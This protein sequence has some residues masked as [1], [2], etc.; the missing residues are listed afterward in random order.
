MVLN[1]KNRKEYVVISVS[2]LVEK[3]GL[4]DLIRAIPLVKNRI[5]LEIVGS[6]PLKNKLKALAEQLGI[7]GRVIFQGEVAHNEV[8]DI[9]KNVDVF[10]RPSLSE[11]LGTAFIEAMAA[12][13]P[14]IGTPVGGITDLIT[15]DETG[16]LCTPGDVQGIADA[17]DKILDDQSFA[18]KISCAG[19]KFVNNLE[20]GN[21]A[22]KYGNIYREYFQRSS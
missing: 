17:I 7:E 14:V 3:N 20:W 19:Q 12:G 11:G 21:I 9:L 1:I 2:R 8:L 15:N 13:L 16:V 6:G 5:R 4:A 22:S 10:V 18:K